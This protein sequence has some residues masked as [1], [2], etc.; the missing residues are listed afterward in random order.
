MLVHLER[1]RRKELQQTSYGLTG[2][3]SV[4]EKP[5]R[6]WLEC[7]SM[8]VAHISHTR[9]WQLRRRIQGHCRNSR[10]TIPRKDRRK[11]EGKRHQPENSQI[12]EEG[13]TCAIMAIAGWIPRGSKEDNSQQKWHLTGIVYRIWEST[14]LVQWRKAR[15]DI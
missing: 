12:S 3:V 7:G 1:E 8:S 15:S 6:R 9:G 13:L 5:D 11:T 2:T 4:G 14:R 10:A